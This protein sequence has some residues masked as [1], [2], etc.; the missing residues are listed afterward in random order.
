MSMPGQPDTPSA[1]ASRWLELSVEAPGEYAETIASLFARHAEGV[2]SEQP[3]G[4]NPDEGES[5]PEDAPITVRGYLPIDSTTENRRAMIDVGIRLIS[6]LSPLPPMEEREVDQSEWANQ[7]FEPIRIGKRLVIVP[8][9]Y[10]PPHAGNPS[11]VGARHASPLQGEHGSEA[12]HSFVPS[13]EAVVIPLEPGLAFGTGHHPTTAMMLTAMEQLVTPNCAVLDV[14]CGSGILMI[15]AMKLG[16]GSAVGCDVE[17]D[18]FIS[19]RRNIELAGIETGTRV[20]QGSLPSDQAPAGAFDLVLA[21]IS[22]NIVSALAGEL[23]ECLKP[24]G[25]LLASGILEHRMDEVVKA[26]ES[27]GGRL[28]DHEIT[29]DWCRLTLGRA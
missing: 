7:S 26:L 18:S 10:E 16:A 6:H 12:A 24:D 11:Q 22:A 3:G 25:T 28:V 2:Y 27:A 23:I 21:N 14:G 29:G 4:Y 9:S 5:A 20:F 19:S 17:D 13:L 15:A 1:S 8:P